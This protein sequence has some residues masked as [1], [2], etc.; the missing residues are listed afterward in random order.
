MQDFSKRELQ[1]Y[2][3]ARFGLFSS[4][5]WKDLVEDVQNMY[6][7]YNDVSNINSTEEFWQRKGYVEFLNWFLSL[8]EVSKAAYEGIV[9]EASV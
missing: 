6:K 5:G 2:Y 7:N 8:E 1:D 9:N 3:E 4:K